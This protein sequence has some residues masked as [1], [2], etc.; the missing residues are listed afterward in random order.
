MS[1][2][3]LLT[4]AF[5]NIG[6]H[7]LRHLL[8]AGH[9]V[10]C[11]D[12]ASDKNR[13]TAATFGD[14]VRVIWGDL[15]QPEVIRASLAGVDTVVHMAGI[16]PPLSE[17]NPAL[18]TAVNVDATAGLIRAMEESGQARRL[19]FASSMGVAG[20]E[21]HR[22]QPPLTVDLPTSPSDHY[23]QTKV[24]CEE[25]IRASALQW[26]I[27]RIA[28]CPPMDLGTGDPT[29]LAIMFEASVDGR[30]EFVH[31]DDA[32]LA[33]A[34]AV[35]CDAAI[36]KVLFI[37]GGERCRTRALDFYNRLLGTMG[38]GPL[39]PEKFRP[40]PSYFF[41]DWLDTQESQAL[42]RFQRHSLDDYFTAM[43]QRVGFKR[44]LMRLVAPLANRHI[45]KHSP[46]GR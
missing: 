10:V 4:G 6:S 20:Q 26:S 12:L 37:G 41:G 21:Q 17:H 24:R 40:G 19:V 11:L 3:V 38:L 16:I 15:Q 18:A 29:Q 30:A 7:V 14:R 8:A 34:N 46:Y 27:L 13:R 5:G 23:G 39:K 2:T 25:L 33:F 44:H 42:L 32:G 45:E 22:R 31:M 1:K 36:G 43:R 9:R 35:D 28:A